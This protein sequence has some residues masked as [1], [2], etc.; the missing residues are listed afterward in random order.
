MR[1]GKRGGDRCGRRSSSGDARLNWRQQDVRTEY[2]LPGAGLRPAQINIL[3]GRGEAPPASPSPTPRAVLLHSKPSKPD[4]RGS[5]PPNPSKPGA[6]SS[7]E[8]PQIPYYFSALWRRSLDALSLAGATPH[9]NS[10]AGLRPAQTNI[11][12]GRG[13]APPAQTNILVGRGEAPPVSLDL[14][15]GQVPSLDLAAGQVSSLDLAAGQVLGFSP[16]SVRPPSPSQSAKLPLKLALLWN[17]RPEMGQAFVIDVL[18]VDSY[19]ELSDQARSDLGLDPFLYSARRQIVPSDAMFERLFL[20]V[21]E[22][23]ENDPVTFYNA[24]A[25]E[26]LAHCLGDEFLWAQLPATKTN[27][28]HFPTRPW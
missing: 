14:A 2:P 10:G 9:P 4:G 27:M 3:V 1:R 13:E 11:L 6:H 22:L 28:L 24:V 5:A 26:L 16:N 15:A 17:E 7:V 21:V 19:C 8:L 20:R 18:S 25:D 23:A 12:V